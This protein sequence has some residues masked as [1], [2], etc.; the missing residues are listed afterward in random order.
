MKPTIFQRARKMNMTNQTASANL[1][2]LQMLSIRQN[3][4]RNQ[5]AS[6]IDHNSKA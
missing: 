2:G 3:T 1:Y 6:V 5:K 4:A